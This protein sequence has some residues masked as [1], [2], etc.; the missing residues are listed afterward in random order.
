[1]PE[2]SYAFTID[3]DC[4]SFFLWIF[5]TPTLG[6]VPKG[7]AECLLTQ[8]DVS[9]PSSLLTCKLWRTFRK[10]FIPVRCSTSW[11]T[12]TSRVGMMAIERVRITRAKRDH[13]RFR[14][15]WKKTQE[16]ECLEEGN[17]KRSGEV[18]EDL[19]GT[20]LRRDKRAMSSSSRLSQSQQHVP[21]WQTGRNRFLSWWSSAP[22]PGSPPPRCRERQ[23]RS[24]TPAQHPGE[25]REKGHLR[26]HHKHILDVTSHSWLHTHLYQAMCWH[27]PR[28]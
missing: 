3:Q 27:C 17:R 24:N 15:P 25:A 16:D 13:F 7:N 8:R 14:N 9:F 6:L 5:P 26:Q 1:M 11:K 28:S 20:E 12:A 19:R 22:Q 10:S 2:I 4:G 23:A 21:P 18:W